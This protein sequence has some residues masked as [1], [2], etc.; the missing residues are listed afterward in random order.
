MTGAHLVRTLVLLVLLLPALAEG[1]E[2]SGDRPSG[3]ALPERPA[4]Q[5]WF[6][7]FCEVLIPLD[8][9]ERLSLG[10]TR[11]SVAGRSFELL[12]GTLFD[13]DG[14]GWVLVLRGDRAVVDLAAAEVHLDPLGRKMRLRPR[15]GPP[16]RAASC[17]ADVAFV[18][19]ENP[20]EVDAKVLSGFPSWADAGASHDVLDEEAARERYRPIRDIRDV[21]IEIHE[22]SLRDPE[23]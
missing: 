15:P 9:A 5:T 16:V 13:V 20:P 11:L 3:T 18:V 7:W 17:P 1:E 12:P 21:I 2:A 23:R 4:D 19:F 6:D 22:R 8:D 10:F 14:L